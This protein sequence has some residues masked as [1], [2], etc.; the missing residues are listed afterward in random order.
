MRPDDAAVALDRHD[1]DGDDSDT[2]GPDAS[3]AAPGEPA[4]DPD[5]VVDDDLLEVDLG[6]LDA[7]L[8]IDEEELDDD[9]LDPIED[10]DED[11]LEISLLQELGI[12]LDAPDAV[13]ASLDIG[14]V[15]EEDSDDEVAA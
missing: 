13:A 14:L 12:D 15:A 8:I 5:V 6:E 9:I 11:D 10:E 2:F 3:A 7:P 1:F 4:A